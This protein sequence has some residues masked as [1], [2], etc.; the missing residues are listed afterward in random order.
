MQKLMLFHKIE[1]FISVDVDIPQITSPLSMGGKRILQQWLGSLCGK[2]FS[3]D[4]SSLW[5]EGEF[6]KSKMMSHCCE[7]YS[8]QHHK[9]NSKEKLRK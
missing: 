9:P 5:K 6:K 2:V 8:S 3:K 7:K 1:R 4:L